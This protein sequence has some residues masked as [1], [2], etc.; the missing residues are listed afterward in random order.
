MQ[1]STKFE[2][3]SYEQFEK[4][5]IKTFSEDTENKEFI[6]EVYENIK[7]P[8][9]SSTGSAG[10]DFFMPVDFSFDPGSEGIIPTGIRCV[11]MPTDCVLMVYSRSGLGTKY[12]FNIAQNVAVID[13]DYSGAKNEGHIFIRM[14]NNG[15]QGIDFDSGDAFCQGVLM[16][17]GITIDDNADGKRTGGFGSSDNKH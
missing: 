5:W 10:Y 8:K 2:K 4:D 12:K 7:L 6:K 9:R 16:Q 11:D 15:N 3:V 1:T 13:S 17:Y 14:V